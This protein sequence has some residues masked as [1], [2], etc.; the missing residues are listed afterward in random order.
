MGMC[1]ECQGVYSTDK[2]GLCRGCLKIADRTA[3][4]AA[5]VLAFESL[6]AP[7]P[8]PRAPIRTA[9]YHGEAFDVMWNG[10]VRPDEAT[11]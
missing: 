4:V 10:V 11:S 7:E 1:K 5:S 9:V 8:E 3:I 2:S 6:Q